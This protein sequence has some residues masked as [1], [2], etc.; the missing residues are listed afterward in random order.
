MLSAGTTDKL[1]VSL[2]F[3][4]NYILKFHNTGFD[5]QDLHRVSEALDIHASPELIHITELI[6]SDV[7]RPYLRIIHNSL[8]RYRFLSIHEREIQHIAEV[9]D[10]ESSAYNFA[11][12]SQ[13]DVRQHYQRL[14]NELHDKDA[15]RNNP[16]AYAETHIVLGNMALWEREYD[17]A[18]HY[19]ST[20]TWCLAQALGM[21]HEPSSAQS[22]LHLRPASLNTSIAPAFN[23]IIFSTYVESMLLQGQTEEKRQDFTRAAAIYAHLEHH[24]QRFNQQLQIY[25]DSKKEIYYL[26]KW[27]LLF[28]HLKRGSSHHKRAIKK[29]TLSD[30]LPDVS[31][32]ISYNRDTSMVQPYSHLRLG[33]LKLFFNHTNE[34]QYHFKKVIQHTE[35]LHL[36]SQRGA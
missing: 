1:V 15:Q 5:H 27:I 19:Y 3:L 7:L 24:V 34:C 8:H 13:R 36:P 23:Q 10:I 17:K 14:L 20:A 18:V 29:L 30:I 28:L 26:A 9:S 11:L 25:S 35:T 4:L 22:A 33:T 6:L 32:Y 2:F 16:S 12:D 21:H 31:R